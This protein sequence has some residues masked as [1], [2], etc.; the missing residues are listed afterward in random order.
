MSVSARVVKTPE[1]RERGP[2]PEGT[3]LHEV[4]ATTDSSIASGAL[5][6]VGFGPVVDGLVWL[7]AR[8]DDGAD[9]RQSHQVDRIVQRA[10][11][12]PAGS[13]VVLCVAA[14]QWPSPGLQY[15]RAQGRH[16][17]RVTVACPDPET[18][19]RWVHA[20]RGA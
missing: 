13:H 3:A 16:L 17:G 14:G 7:D 9:G 6:V 5:S 1:T 20:L 4:I 12:A 11:D 15:V 19:R 8:L 2:R 18:V 10:C